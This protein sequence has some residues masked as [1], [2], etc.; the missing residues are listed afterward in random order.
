MK[1]K[2]IIDNPS[3]N[4]WIHKAMMKEYFSYIFY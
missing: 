3:A 2:N 4:K 1:K